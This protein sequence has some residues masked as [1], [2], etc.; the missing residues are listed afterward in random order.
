[1]RLINLEIIDGRVNYSRSQSK[2]FTYPGSSPTAAPLLDRR[3]RKMFRNGKFPVKNLLVY[4]S[5]GFPLKL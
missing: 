5:G 3:K 1:M 2:L 4:Y